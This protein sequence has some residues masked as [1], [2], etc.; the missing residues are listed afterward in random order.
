MLKLL[1]LGCGNRKKSG[2]IGIDINPKTSAD[3]IHDLN[4]CPYPFKDSEYDQ[5]YADNVIEHLNDVI[6]VVE[7]IHRI[8]KPGAQVVIYVPYFRSRWAFID[9]THKHFF[10]V[11]S[12]SYYDPEHANNRLFPYS[13]AKFKVEKIIFNERINKT[14][15]IGW[16]VNNIV[17]RCANKDPKKYESFW[18][19]IFPLDE[20][21]FILR[22]IK[23]INEK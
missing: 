9:P 2:A 3:V 10:T 22:V 13:N 16:F 7:E 17:R 21:T 8:S 11:E 15:A 5:V 4:K 12:F 19:Q 20:L 23:D 18:S 1:D 14:G 6:A